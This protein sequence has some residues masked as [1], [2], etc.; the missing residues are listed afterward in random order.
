MLAARQSMLRLSLSPGRA[1][2]GLPSDRVAPTH[3]A[4]KTKTLACLEATGDPTCRV[5]TD[6]C[7]L[8]RPTPRWRR[9]TQFPQLEDMKFPHGVCTTTPMS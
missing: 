7:M 8:A 5:G 1:R 6:C 2:N 9:T 4:N 3:P